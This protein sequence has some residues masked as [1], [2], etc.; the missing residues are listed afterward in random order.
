GIFAYCLN[1]DSVSIWKDVPGV[2][3][4]DPRVFNT[5]QLLSHISYEEAIELAF[6]GASVIHPKT[7]HPLQR[8]EIPLY[9]KPFLN[10]EGLGT[11]V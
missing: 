6:H 7:I 3:N 1:A 11:S 10:P 9:V 5:T 4:A 8:K 2:L